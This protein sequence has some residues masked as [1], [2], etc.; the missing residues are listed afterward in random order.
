MNIYLD[1]NLSE[2]VADA[3]NSLNKG[4]FSHVVVESTKRRFG[5]GE[6]DEVLISEIGKDKGFLI[7]RDDRIR[8]SFQ[9]ELCKQHGLGSF[10]IVLPKNLDRH[11]ELVKLLIYHWEEVIAKASRERKPFAYRIRMRGKMQRM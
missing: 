1:E 6:Q 2:F 7:T 11:W 8:T 10:F 4:Y 5:K 9:Y 3:L